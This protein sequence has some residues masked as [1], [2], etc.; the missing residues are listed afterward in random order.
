MNIKFGNCEVKVNGG[1]LFI[2]TLVL[3]SFVDNIYANHCKKNTI[4]KLFEVSAKKEE[5]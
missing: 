1:L 3:G 5:S 4:N 2:G